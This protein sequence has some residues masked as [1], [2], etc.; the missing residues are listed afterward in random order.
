MVTEKWS[1]PVQRNRKQFITTTS[2]QALHPLM[3]AYLSEAFPCSSQVPGSLYTYIQYE[4]WHLRNQMLSLLFSVHLPAREDDKHSLPRG[5]FHVS[6]NPRHASGFSGS[7]AY[8]LFLS[9][10]KLGKSP[11]WAGEPWVMNHRCFPYKAQTAVGSTLTQE[12]CIPT[13]AFRNVSVGSMRSFRY[14]GTESLIYFFPF[15][16]I[17]RESQ[18]LVDSTVK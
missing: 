5:S 8:D 12:L 10:V 4:P 6:N 9:V 14:N 1:L 11:G 18:S 13:G 16:G 7:Q 3:I 17:T 15:S 2:T